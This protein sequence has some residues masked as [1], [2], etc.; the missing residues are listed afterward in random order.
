MGASAWLKSTLLLAAFQAEDIKPC[1]DLAQR[2]V[3]E[4]PA[5]WH[6]KSML[7]DL[8]RTLAYMRDAETRAKLQPILK[9]IR[10]GAG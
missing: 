8:D 2:T 3:D 6:L 4:G 5:V 1:E 7:A 10:G 9:R